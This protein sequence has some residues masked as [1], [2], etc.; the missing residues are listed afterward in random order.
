MKKHNFSAGPAILPASVIKEAA[1]GVLELDGIGMSILEIS[2]RSAE[3]IAIAAEAESL[4]R[5]LLQIPADYAV[6]FLS[7]GASGQFSMSAMN[8]LNENQSAGYLDTGTWSSKAIKEA[9]AFGKVQVLASSKDQN[10]NY[11]PTGYDIPAGLRYVHVTSNNTIFGTQLREFP[12]TDAPLVADMSSD[13]FSRRIPL[14]KFG[15]IYAGAQKNMGPAGVTLVIVRKDLLGQVDRHLPSMLDYRIHIENE[16]MFNTPPVYPIYVS[17]LTMRWVKAQGG[18]EA[19]ER[20]NEA[21]AKL[22]YDEIERNPR[23]QCTVP[24]PQ[25][26]SLMNV[27]FVCTDDADTKPFLAAAEAAGCDG[28]KGHRSVGGFRAS[29]YNSMPLESVQ[30][31]VDVMKNF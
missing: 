2:H 23:F 24:N 15:L 25:D 21:K 17:M 26:R 3:F 6:L 16:S 30:V 14:E 27:T 7:G 18:L 20:H 4:A 9:K 11:I 12:T 5:E 29:I 8:L 31:L 19:M 22:L 13:I 28:I 1:A 10:Y